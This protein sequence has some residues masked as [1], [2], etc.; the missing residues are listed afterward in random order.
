MVYGLD[1]NGLD[2]GATCWACHITIPSQE[3]REQSDYKED[4]DIVGSEFNDEVHGKLKKQTSTDRK[5]YRGIRKDITSFFGVRASFDEESG[6]V[7]R[8]YYPCTINYEL[9]GYKTRSHPKNFRSPGPIGET[10]KQCDLFGQFRFKTHGHTVIICPGEEDLMAVYQILVDD[11]K[12]KGG[13][14]DAPAVVSATIG[15]SG[16]HKQIQQQ[17]QWLNQF[18]KIVVCM[19][20]DTAGKEAA[21][22]ICSILPTGKVYRMTM[23]FKDPNEYIWDKETDQPRNFQK[24][25]IQDFWAAKQYTPEGVKTAADAFDLKFAT[26]YDLEFTKAVAY[27][28]KDNLNNDNQMTENDKSWIEEKFSGILNL[29]KG[30]EPKKGFNVV[31]LKKGTIVNVDVT[32]ANGVIITFPDVADGA[33]P[34]IGDIAT[35][36]GKPAEG[37]YLMPDGNTYVFVDGELTQVVEAGDVEVDVVDALTAEVAQL[38]EQLATQTTNYEQAV[39][40]LKAQIVSKFETKEP[41]E[42][43]K[44][45]QEPKTRKLLK[46]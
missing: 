33:M 36:D 21:E 25:F 26:E 7:S 8:T 34:T 27:L 10:G 13:K 35:I 16:A 41:K 37:E 46:D 31:S 45:N 14:Y 38:K 43:P 15:E 5:G 3:I 18:K 39:V 44:D 19:D 11:Q 1:K 22:K 17:Y 2:L 9:S 6:E 20:N 42:A 4:E 24:E 40:N 12:A 28:K 23:R 30:K 32:D 29:I